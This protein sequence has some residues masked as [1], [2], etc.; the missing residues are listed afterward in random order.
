[1]ISRVED[2]I[3]DNRGSLHMVPVDFDIKHQFLS[4][5]W[6]DVV[7]GM[8]YQTDT[9]KRV[10]VVEGEILDVG[11]CLVTGRYQKVVLGPG[12][13][14]CI[15]LYMAHGFW[16]STDCTILY[17]YSQPW[18][19]DD[20]YTISPVDSF[21]DLPWKH[22]DANLIISDKDRNAPTWKEFQDVHNP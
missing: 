11:L 19:P 5:S 22:D 13:T 14:V 9:V 17:Q 12:D 8:H 6:A 2:S 18:N 10:T 16:A 7:R 15:P 21:L 1:M 3:V 20:E 4:C